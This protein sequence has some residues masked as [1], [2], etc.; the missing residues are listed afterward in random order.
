[1]NITYV[2]PDK[3]R[4]ITGDEA[5]H[6]KHRGSVIVEGTGHLTLWGCVQGSLSVEVDGQVTIHGKQQGSVSVDERGRVVVTGAIDGSVYVS[7][8]AVVVVEQGG[9]L[10]GSLHN[11]G[12]VIVRGAFGGSQ[13]GAG[14]LRLEGSGYVKAPVIRDGASFYSW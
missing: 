14:E 8:G 5:M 9:R 4:I 13:S 7:P 11:D 6:E 1:M 2:Q 10:A 3:D 12:L